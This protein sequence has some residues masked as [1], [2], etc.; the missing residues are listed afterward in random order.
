MN[1]GTGFMRT[2]FVNEKIPNHNDFPSEEEDEELTGASS[3]PLGNPP[4]SRGRKAKNP[5][6]DTE[7]DDNPGPSL[8]DQIEDRTTATDEELHGGEEG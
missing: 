5:Y 8:A 1:L 2:V 6:E 7:A 3:D 4:G